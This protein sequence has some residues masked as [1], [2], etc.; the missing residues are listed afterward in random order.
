MLQPDLG[1]GEGCNTLIHKGFANVNTRKR[2]LYYHCYIPS[3][4]VKVFTIQ[5]KNNLSKFL[6]EGFNVHS[7]TAAEGFNPNEA[8]SGHFLVSLSFA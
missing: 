5:S 6:T 1:S 8:R 2:L 3:I 4:L 7:Y